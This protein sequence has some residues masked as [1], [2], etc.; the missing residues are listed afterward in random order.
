[1]ILAG[2]YMYLYPYP[3][4]YDFEAISKSISDATVIGMHVSTDDA[5]T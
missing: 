4:G 1:M 5:T 2:Y 3:Y